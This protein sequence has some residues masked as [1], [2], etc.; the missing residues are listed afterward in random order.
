MKDETGL[1][2]L[3]HLDGNANDDSGFGNDG[4]VVGA[5]IT[6]EGKFGQAYKFDGKPGRKINTTNIVGTENVQ[7]LTVS[8]WINPLTHNAD[9]PGLAVKGVEGS[10]SSRYGITLGP[11]GDYNIHALMGN[12][13][14]AGGYTSN[15]IIQKNRWY[16][17]A[18][19]YNGTGATNTDKLKLYL[20]GV[21]QS[22]TYYGILAS[23]TPTNGEGLLI[24][25]DPSGGN[26]LRIFNGTI[27]EVR[28]YN[29][30]LSSSEILEL[31]NQSLKSHKF[32]IRGK[33]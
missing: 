22:L 19:V 10:G 29:R 15:N 4:T 14:N 32:V 30:S 2:G 21:S 3:W 9:F 33:P 23:S 8:L 18:M 12:N 20:N 6:N 13:S 31:Y 25:N 26:T 5:T 28:I 16:H 11:V 1:V 17:V 24:G 27:D 7:H